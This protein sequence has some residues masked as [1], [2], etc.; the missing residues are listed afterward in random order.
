MIT[1]TITE[2]QNET[3]EVKPE[4]FRANIKKVYDYKSG[5]SEKTKKNWSLQPCVVSDGTKEMRVVF[6]GRN[7]YEVSELEGKEL[8]VKAKQNKA[9]AY[10]GMML[11]IGEYNGNAQKEL[12]V[13][14]WADVSFGDDEDGS[15]VIDHPTKSESTTTTF[16]EEPSVSPVS[17]DAS[18]DT[19]KQELMKATNLMLVC[20]DASRFVKTQYES[21]HGDS[22]T[23]EHFQAICSSLFINADKR[24]LTSSMP[25]QPIE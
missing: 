18:L 13:Y 9:G 21:K 7:Q 23:P 15:A 3:N 14:D 4:A 8:F 24:G 16:V 10:S 1:S 11:K 19:A 12:F 25:T 17:S 2:L 6:S 20:L 5:Y 22:M